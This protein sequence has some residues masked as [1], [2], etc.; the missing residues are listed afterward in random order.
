[1]LTV[2]NLAK[3]FDGLT[4]VNDLNFTVE[5]NTISGLIGPNGAGKT[6]TFNMIAGHL[7]PSGGKIYFDGR[8]ITNLRPHQ[9]FQLGIVRT[10][11]IPR[12]FSGMTVLE[13]L[14]M[15]P[16][17]QIGEK[18]WNNWLRNNAVEREEQQIREKA[19][20]LLEFLNLSDL[21][22]EYSGN[23][24]GGQL[25]LLELGRALMSDPK[26]ILLDEPAAGVNPT[27]LEEI[28]GRIRD[29]HSQGV[30]FLIIEH[31]MELVMRLCS[32]I[33]VMAEGDILMRGGPEEVRSDPRLIDAFL[34]GGTSLK[35]G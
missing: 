13:N 12:P 22:N 15:V 21:Q 28:I 35:N 29:I 6:T 25:K 17:N 3:E 32:S 31:N 9:T 16:R 11:Q 34:G 7:K 30:T 27:L 24:S 19:N 4:A 18:I 14:T 20:G 23:L 2:E 1:M 5:P 10:F 26:M 8:E 33:L